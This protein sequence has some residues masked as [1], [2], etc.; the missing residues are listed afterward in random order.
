MA[1]PPTNIQTRHTICSSR[2]EPVNRCRALFR[3]CF[4]LLLQQLHRGPEPTFWLKVSP[5]CPLVA[6]C[7]TAFLCVCVIC[8]V[9]FFLPCP[10]VGCVCVCAYSFSSGIKQRETSMQVCTSKFKQMRQ[11]YCASCIVHRAPQKQL[12]MAYARFV[13]AGSLHFT[14]FASFSVHCLFCPS[15]ASPVP[16]VFLSQQPTYGFS[17]LS[18]L[19]GCLRRSFLSPSV[20]LSLSK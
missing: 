9:I 2:P 1:P 7:S 4:S 3:S 5:G 6:L 10:R 17:C 12:I 8:I 16:I 11:L 13:E 14:N 20:A 19:T 15:S 18:R